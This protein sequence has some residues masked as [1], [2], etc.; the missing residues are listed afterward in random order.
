MPFFWMLVP[1]LQVLFAIHA[2]KRGNTFWMCLIIFFPGVGV[3]IYLFAE[4]LPSLR[5]DQTVQTIST[6][7]GKRMLPDRAIQRLR[8]EVA[9]NNSVNNRITLADALL[10]NNQVEEAINLYE[11][12]LTGVYKDDPEMLLKITQAYFI[13]NDHTETQKK[14]RQLREQHPEFRPTEITRLVALSHEAAGD[15]EKAIP[16]YE[17]ILK[18]STGEEIRCRYAQVLK[19]TGKIPEALHQFETIL[20]NIRVSPAYYKSSERQWSAV[21]KSEIRQLQ[22]GTSN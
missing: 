2:Y 1:L 15:F 7:I 18:I 12:C 3:L 13:K 9:L 19:R 5:N 20:Q 22:N 8:D 17:S 14:C 11:S 21:A 16:E 10:Q 4:F 6:S